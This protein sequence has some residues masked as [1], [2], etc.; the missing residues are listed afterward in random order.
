MRTDQIKILFILVGVWAGFSFFIGVGNEYDLQ[1]IQERQDSILVY[2]DSL[3]LR[4][5][6]LEHTLAIWEATYK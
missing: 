1:K 3:E 5:E 6:K 2:Q 4:V